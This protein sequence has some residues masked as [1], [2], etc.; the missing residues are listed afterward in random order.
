M[1][2]IARRNPFGS[3]ALKISAILLA[4]GASTA[5]A[6]AI[7]LVVFGTLAGAVGD[8][9]H[10]T[11]PELQASVA[12]IA[13]SGTARD[14]L[15]EMEQ[16]RTE[17]ELPQG[18]SRLDEATG[19]LAEAVGRLPAGDA[20]RIQ[21]M[22]EGLVKAAD[23]MQSAMSAQ[24]DAGTRMA[25]EIGD[26]SAV[27]D[28][29]RSLLARMSDDAQ[30]ELTLGGE[31]TVDTV[32]GTLATL[33]DREFA[34]MQ[35]VLDTRAEINLV[36]GMALALIQTKDPAFAAILRD[37]AKSGLEHLD[38]LLGKLGED[39]S[40]AEDL[41]AILSARDELQSLAARNFA[42]RPGIQEDLLTLR[43][44]SD[45]ALSELIDTMSFDLA[46]MAED[47]ASQN[48]S[49]IRDLLTA[50]VGKMRGAAELD[51]AVNRLFVTALLG[52]AASDL[53]AVGAQ[54][55][56]LNEAVD[57]LAALSRTG[58]LD[59]DLL[60]LLDRV[61]AASDP[62]T[63]LLRARRDYLE[64]AANA[65]ARADDASA[66]LAGIAE[67]ARDNGAAATAQMAS[68]GESVLGETEKARRQMHIIGAV[69]LAILL[70]A[71]V[72]SW[73]L[74]LRP[75][76][77]VTRVTERLAKGDLAPVTGFE[78]TSG[79]VGRMAAALAVFRDGL[80]ER[81]AMQEQERTREAERAADERAAAEEKHRREAEA[82]AEKARR[83][84]EEREREAEMAARQ[85]EAD[86]TAQAERDARSS[87]QAAVVDTLADA[88]KRLSSGDLTISIDTAFADAYEGLR[89]NFNLAVRSI[90]DLIRSLTEGASTV[91]SSSADIASAATEL[92]RR[93][94]Q[95]AASLE[96]TA[97]AVAELDATAK[98]TSDAAQKADKVMNDARQQAEDTRASV[99]SAVS[100]MSEIET[101]SEAVSKIV[102]LIESIAFQT[103]LLAL[104]AGVEAARAGEQ[105]RGFA[106][107]ATE[108]RGLAQR[109][110]EAAS[111]INALI[112]ATRGQISQGV[113]QVNA[114]GSA[115]TGILSM[116]G[117]ISVQ[118]QSIANGAKEQASTVSDVNSSVTSLDSSMQKNAAMFEESLAASELLRSKSEELLDLSMRFRIPNSDSELPSADRSAA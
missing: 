80:I 60:G 95:N 24:F 2:R 33:T 91:H 5:A 89:T 40:L 12:V 51:A 4:M 20:A 27:A 113:T 37:V 7:A 9:M 36:S 42:G 26:F 75:M 14:A 72:L 102:D 21:P 23:R 49:A 94:E 105:G 30:H 59:N 71:P 15:A 31:N 28:E 92:A 116:I 84:Q 18:R 64:A 118:V 43:Q 115:L 90:S 17:Q 56:R 87:E 53:E 48:E 114:A 52:A 81:E 85:A 1:A 61:M 22:I 45:A 8:L 55:V 109:A 99:D 76:A 112:S 82:A 101:S 38:R 62:E 47:T 41:A 3:I 11:L 46:I 117:E 70:A 16:A 13:R 100:T 103:N 74:I 6:V 65:T 69:S 68:A 104:N 88:L 10:T 34:T 39:A 107:V 96:E 93:T 98:L 78:R 77:R 54:Q 108:V 79:E 83:A 73:L 63:G 58:T 111:E 66:K 29:A 97:A 25:A 19:A 44:K 50:Q 32:R 106:V 86:R 57:Q 35:A 67:A 110:S